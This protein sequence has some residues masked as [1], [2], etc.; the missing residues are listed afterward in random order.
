MPREGTI[1]DVLAGVQKKVN[2]DDETIRNARVFEVHNS[3]IYREF[4]QDSRF[5]G[6]NDF[7]AL[8]AERI[9]D[10]ELE[11]ENGA[12]AIS[13]FN[14]DKETNRPHSVPFKFVVKPVSPSW[15]ELTVR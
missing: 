6:S 13:A 4:S 2:L 3:K 14:F 9:P 7:V 10:E 5:G 8:Y 15:Y 11:M 12:R 1:E